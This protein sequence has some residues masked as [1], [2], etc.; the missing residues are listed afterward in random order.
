MIAILVLY[1]LARIEDFLEISTEE[2]TYEITTEISWDK[3][4]E[5]KSIFKDHSMVIN[6]YKQEKRDKD[7]VCTFDV[8]G[9]TK[10]HDKLV[11]KLLSDKEIKELWF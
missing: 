4:K 5:L 8:M 10:K 3:F 9:T 2:R 1:P 6:S 11:Q 7:M